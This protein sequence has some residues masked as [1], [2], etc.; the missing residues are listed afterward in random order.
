[1]TPDQPDLPSEPVTRAELER[2]YGADGLVRVAPERVPAAVADPGARAFL[3][4]IGLPTAPGAV[5]RPDEALLAGAPRLLAEHCAPGK[6]DEAYPG[7]PGGGAAMVV[8]GH[9]GSGLFVLDGGSGA[10]HALAPHEDAAVNGRPAHR[11][12]HSLARCLLA[13]GGRELWLLSD[14]MDPDTADWC[15]AHFPEFAELCP[16]RDEE[17]DDF[18]LD[19]DEEEELRARMPDVDEVLDGLAA[20]LRRIEPGITDQPVWQEVLHNFR[21]GY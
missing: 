11:D 6:P 10:V 14:L 21:H 19:E 4:A 7:L 2:V 20:A 9:Y 17:D 3:T 16:V 18:F 1:M 12:L 8:L 5:V 15:R 13:F